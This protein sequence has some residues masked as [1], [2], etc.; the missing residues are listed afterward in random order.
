M[1]KAMGVQIWTKRGWKN[2]DDVFVGDQV[3]SYNPKRNCTEYDEVS[4][5]ILDYGSNHLLGYRN[6]SASILMTKDHPVLVIDKSTALSYR[7]QIDDIFLD[8]LVKGRSMLYN[9][10]F[11][12]YTVTKDPEDV[13]WSARMAATF[14][15]SERLIP[16][17]Y[18]DQIW[19]II[20]DLN[21]LQAQQWIE[22]FYSWSR[23]APSS[24]WMHSTVLHNRQLRDMLFHVGPKAGLGVQLH[25]GF[26]SQSR[27]FFI[28]VSDTRDLT[29]YGLESWKQERHIGSV[30]NVST[31]NGSFLARSNSGTF[32]VACDIK[33]E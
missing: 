6:K 27:K 19:D 28:S 31:K 20:K 16:I 26:G 25:R 2:I 13:L 11:E 8:Y 18:Q 9:R 3:I 29:I 32:I 15:Y 5:I 22:Q 7:Q 10:W 23:Q 17:K 12:P 1:I 24:I 4:N 14:I 30:F 33:E 21:G